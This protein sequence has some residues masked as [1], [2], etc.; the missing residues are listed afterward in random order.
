M[1]Q[2]VYYKNFSGGFT[3]E[4]RQRPVCLPRA[5]LN[6]IYNVDVT[7]FQKIQFRCNANT[8]YA[9]AFTVMTAEKHLELS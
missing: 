5:L 7:P 9:M 4:M 2:E 3:N 8:K 6:F 1:E